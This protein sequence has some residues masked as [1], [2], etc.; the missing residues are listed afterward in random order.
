MTAR[1]AASRRPVGFSVG[2][3]GNPRAEGGRPIIPGD[4]SDGLSGIGEVYPMDRSGAR[5]ETRSY[6][7]SSHDNIFI[8]AT[9]AHLSRDDGRTC[10]AEPARSARAGST[11]PTGTRPERSTDGRGQVVATAGQHHRPS[12]ASVTIPRAAMHEVAT[13]LPVLRRLYGDVPSR[14]PAFSGDRLEP[15]ADLA[16]PWWCPGRASGDRP[17]RRLQHVLR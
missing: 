14:Q 3:A 1:L 13:A 16:H 9:M 5:R 15:L 17:L 6:R 12:S 7:S 10:N 2:T 8:I 11:V 4:F